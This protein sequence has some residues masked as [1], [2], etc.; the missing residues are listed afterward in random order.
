MG[1]NGSMEGMMGVWCLSFLVRLEGTAFIFP[2]FSV[3]FF[4]DDEGDRRGMG[5]L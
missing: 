3:S 4:A 1:D 2:L 5:G